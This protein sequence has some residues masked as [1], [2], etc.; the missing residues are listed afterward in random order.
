MSKHGMQMG[1]SGYG[2]THGY[3]SYDERNGNEHEMR[4]C[5]EG[6]PSYHGFFVKN[7][8]KNPAARGKAPWLGGSGGSSPPGGT[9][10]YATP[11]V[12][13]GVESGGPGSRSPLGRADLAGPGGDRAVQAGMKRTGMVRDQFERNKQDQFAKMR[14]DSESKAL[15]KYKAGRGGAGPGEPPKPMKAPTP[16]ATPSTSAPK[17]KEPESDLLFKYGQL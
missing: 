4:E 13:Q 15:A 8:G 10:P 14:E 5:T 3:S 7:Q 12:Q 6:S 2:L 16:G 9:G 17:K 1:T 11:L